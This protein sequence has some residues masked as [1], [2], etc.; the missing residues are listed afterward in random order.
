MEQ[1]RI[2]AKAIGELMLDDFCPRCF[3]IKLHCKKLPFQIFAGVVSSLDS[4]EKK[5]INNWVFMRKQGG[6]VPEFFNMLDV[7]GSMKPPHWSKFKCEVPKHGITMT[8]M[9]DAIFILNNGH[10]HITDAK[11]AKWTENQKKILPLYNAQLN[12]YAYIASKDAGLP[13]VDSLSLIY[14]QPQNSDAEAESN[15]AEFGFHMAFKPKFVPVE[16]DIKSLD[17]LLERVRQI[18]DGDLPDSAKGCK[19]C[20]ALNDVVSVLKGD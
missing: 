6:R 7:T 13:P 18:Y 17:P 16:I 19:D 12:G 8:G 11:S 2:S 5:V 10:L 9:C 4:Y 14:F 3:Y 20:V 1:I 15:T